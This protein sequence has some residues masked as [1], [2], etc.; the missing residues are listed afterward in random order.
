MEENETPSYIGMMVSCRNLVH[1][2]HGRFAGYC[3][4]SCTENRAVITAEAAPE[5]LTNL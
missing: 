2:N 4:C 5:F 1:A 3:S